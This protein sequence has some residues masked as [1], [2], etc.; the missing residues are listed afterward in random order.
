MPESHLRPIRRILVGTGLTGESVGA[1]HL[2]H[3]LSQQLSA[4]LHAVHVITP[5]SATAERAIPGLA[6]RHIAQAEE[7]LEKFAAAHDIRG[8]AQLHVVKGQP[9]VEIIRLGMRLDTDL[10][11]IGRYGRGGL[12]HGILGAVADRVVRKNP[13]SVLVVQPEFRGPIQK[14]GVASA[15]ED[16]LNL[17]L[18]R[19]LELAARFGLDSV[20]MIQAYDVPAGYHM[21]STY[22]QASAKLAEVHA[23]IAAEQVRQAGSRI[24]SP[25]QVDIQTRLGKP[26]DVL[27]QFA[28]E[29][30]LD[31]LVIGTHSRTH[32][33]EL[34]LDNLSEQIVKRANC[35]IWAEK[36]T[37]ETQ[38][39]RGFFKTLLD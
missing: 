19:G 37:I 7:E 39:L 11:V 35:N 30:H 17:E 26:I 38:T 8:F 23:K 18:E 15:C 5:I 34:V 33:A 22:E 1:V 16:N 2:A 12:K 4:E 24:N 21:V 31:L 3:W 20:P 27:P 29:A 9:D 32:P 25:P 14:I 28:E 10:L 36:S 6:A 13:T